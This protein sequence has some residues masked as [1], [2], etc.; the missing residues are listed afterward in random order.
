MVLDVIEDTDRECL[1]GSH[2]FEYHGQTD[3]QQPVGGS[4]HQRQK[5]WWGL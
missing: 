2:D 4:E 1:L 5:V 3:I